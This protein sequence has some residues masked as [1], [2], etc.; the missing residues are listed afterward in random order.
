MR[1]TRTYGSAGG[2]AGYSTGPSYPHTGPEDHPPYASDPTRCGQLP[3]AARHGPWGEVL[4]LLALS[5]LALS[6]PKRSKRSKGLPV[7]RALR[8]IPPHG[9]AA[10]AGQRT[11][12]T[13]RR[14]WKG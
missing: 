4:S 7:L 3:V 13:L 1:E 10:S 8:N 6:L 14:G 9:F 5:L 2:G 12:L 11:Q